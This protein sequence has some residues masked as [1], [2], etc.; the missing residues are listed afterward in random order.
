MVID[1]QRS[2]VVRIKKERPIPK[3]EEVPRI[4]SDQ[5]IRELA[6]KAKLP[7]GDD[8]RFAAGVREAALI[9]IAEAS[10]PSHNEVHRE[11]DELLRAADRAVKQR[12]NKDAAYEDVAKRFER[13]SERTRERLK[14]RSARAAALKMPSAEAFRDAARRDQACEAISRLCRIGACWKE[15]RRRPGGKRSMTMVSELHAPELQTHPAR[16][17]AELNFVMNLRLTHLEATGMLP[18]LAVRHVTPTK[19]LPKTAHPRKRLPP[20]AQMAKECLVLLG[21][22]DVD[23]VEMIQKLQRRRNAMLKKP[24]QNKGKKGKRIARRL[25][26][27]KP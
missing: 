25:S 18:P 12:K 1:S 3:A 10:A 9:Y 19:N 27:R 23:V 15:G 4:F 14:D 21:R 7:L 22:R 20:F 6:A 24:S 8:L 13:L 11:V 2:R 17:E 26:P 5:R 16:R